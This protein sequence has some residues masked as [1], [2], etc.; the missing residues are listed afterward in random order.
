VQ[1]TV[2]PYALPFTRPLVTAA[3]TFHQRRGAVLC[4]EHGGWRGVG[5][6][7][8]LPGFSDES[9]DD[10][11]DALDGWQPEPVDSAE[12]LDALLPADLPPSARHGM[13]QALASWAAA[14]TG[15]SLH[16]WL[17]ADDD[18]S[19]PVNALAVD[20]DDATKRVEEGFRTLKVKVAAGPVDADVARVRRIRRAV[21]EGIGLRLD[22]NQGWSPAQATAALE[23]L[24]SVAPELVEE[25][26]ADPA[27]NASLRR[28]APIGADESV[29]SADALQAVIDGRSADAIVV[30]PMLVGGLA[31]SV[32]LLRAAHAAKLHTI[33]TTSL[34]GGVGRCGAFAVAAA[35]PASLACGLD[36]GR[37]LS[38]DV[39][40]GPRIEAGWAR[41]GTC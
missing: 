3:G 4:I 20:D 30:K 5:E 10:A 32:A 27:V 29:R 14:S 24:Q 21:G 6:V 18:A 9:L 34:E 37:W 1:L 17:G 26:T 39:A 31:R 41:A 23:Q 8:P 16:A 28:L 22:A 36:T 7:A 38:S 19:V 33:V 15:R 13:E 12:A 11:L 40:E 25:P 2:R 35:A